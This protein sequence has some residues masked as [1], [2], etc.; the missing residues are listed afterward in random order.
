MDIALTYGD[1][2]GIGPEILARLLSDETRARRAIVCGDRRILAA[3]ADVAGVSVPYDA[4]RFAEVPW[5][6]ELP[7]WGRADARCGA[8]VMAVLERLRADLRSGAIATV[9]T[10]PVHKA[11]VRQVQPEFIGHTEFFAET[12]GVSRFGMLLVVDPL[13]ALHVTSHIALRDVPAKLTVPR[14]LETIELAAEAL[15][16]LGEGGRAIGVCGLNP[17]A[18][19]DGAFGDEEARLIRPAIKA[20][21]ASGI[22]AIGPLPPDA[23]FPQAA[24][25]DYGVVVCMYHDQGHVPL[26]LLGMTRGVNVTVGLPFVRTSVDHGT[27]FDIAGQG[28]AD[29][30]SFVAAW[31]LAMSLQHLSSENPRP[32]RNITKTVG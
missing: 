11:V 29:A 30:G 12:T 20:A 15:I 26:K 9:V 10:G 14:I 17:H 18:G 16:M 2:A 5:S 6:G 13:R 7:P 25:G 8:H 19:E 27:A 3:G 28:R 4:C 23:A 31:N 32:A 1:P 21:V 22:P 24:R